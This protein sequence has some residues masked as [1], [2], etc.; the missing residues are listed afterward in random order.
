MKKK[1]KSNLIENLISFILIAV[2]IYLLAMDLVITNNY[3]FDKEESKY[4]GQCKC[5][6][7]K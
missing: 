6:C 3:F 4:G 5:E 1:N 7:L 2:G